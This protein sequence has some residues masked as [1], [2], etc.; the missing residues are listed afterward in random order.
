MGALWRVGVMVLLV[1]VLVAAQ[2]LRAD[3]WFP[4]GSLGQY[5]YPRDPDGDVINTY[6]M[7][8]TTTGDEVRVGLTP[9]SAG[10]ARVEFETR[11]PEFQAEP[12]LLG[13]IVEAWQDSHPPHV[14]TSVTVYENISPMSAGALASEPYD[15]VVLTWEVP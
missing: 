12:A 7:G 8:V 15:T 10:I 13:D 14:L 3:H 11:L 1:G 5:A 2:F 4:L 9:G 6:V